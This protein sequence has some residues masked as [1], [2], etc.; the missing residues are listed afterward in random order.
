M[1]AARSA[2]VAAK[3]GSFV[4]ED[5]D[6]QPDQ[7]D[8]LAQ[9]DPAGQFCG[10]LR[11]ASVVS[12]RASLESRSQS[13]NP[14]APVWV[15]ISTLAR[16]SAGSRRTTAA[17]VP[18]RRRW[19]T[20]VARMRVRGHGAWSRTARD[21]SPRAG[22]WSRSM[23]PRWYVRRPCLQR[24]P[25]RGRPVVGAAGASAET[26]EPARRNAGGSSPRSPPV[27]QLWTLWIFRATC[28]T[29]SAMRPQRPPDHPG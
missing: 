25:P 6:G 3:V 1:S 21:V 16:W 27:A 9:P 13:T 28:L 12:C 22:H 15:I 23:V 5:L 8:R 14:A 17:A 26:G 29:Q 10:A 11:N 20:R 24:R 18:S 19:R 7:A 4:L 2:S